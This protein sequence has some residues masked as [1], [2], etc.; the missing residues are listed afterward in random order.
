MTE[1]TRNKP[2]TMMR[3]G[4]I[5]QSGHGY[6][7][8][9]RFSNGGSG[10][11][12]GEAKEYSRDPKPGAGSKQKLKSELEERLALFEQ[13]LTHA[14]DEDRSGGG[15]NGE[16]QK[17]PVLLA[18]LE[19]P[20]L[21]K[22]GLENRY[23]AEPPQG[24]IRA[25]IEAI[26]QTIGTRLDAELHRAAPVSPAILSFDIPASHGK[27]AISGFSIALDGNMLTVKLIFKDTAALDDGDGQLIAAAAHLAHA[28]QSRFPNR[29]VKI[30][31]GVQS[32]NDSDT[33]TVSNQ[34]SDSHSEL[35][36]LF[37]REDQ[38]G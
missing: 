12:F 6:Q 19:L 31:R 10:K 5:G 2:N 17:F 14:R 9:A 18:N 13:R 23:R 27:S 4:G 33:Q 11:S 29:G 28:L 36:S 35:A 20:L 24:E 3:N 30:V 8:D 7:S 1:I 22:A 38:S 32:A 16:G 26:V 15:S 34:S 21:G 25:R 37:R